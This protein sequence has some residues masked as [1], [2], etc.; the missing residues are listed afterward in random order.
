[1]YHDK[2]E[3]SDLCN[4]WE[5]L[6]PEDKSRTNPVRTHWRRNEEQKDD[7][8]EEE[9]VKWCEEQNVGYND[10]SDKEHDIT[11]DDDLKKGAGDDE[12]T[13]KVNDGEES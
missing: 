11:W 6:E 2:E 7:I 5:Q 12:N 9:E 10:E 13:E 1:M 8:D 4:K 3:L